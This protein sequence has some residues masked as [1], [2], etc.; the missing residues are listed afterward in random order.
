MIGT[1]FEATGANKRAVSHRGDCD[2]NEEAGWKF[3]FLISTRGKLLSLTWQWKK[4][5]LAS[6]KK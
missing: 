4:R 1:R 3:K 2:F 5:S 6:N